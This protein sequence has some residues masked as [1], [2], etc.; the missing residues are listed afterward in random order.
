MNTATEKHHFT[1]PR[2]EGSKLV[3]CANYTP[4]FD[5]N[6]GMIQ[7]S[8]GQSILSVSLSNN[9]SINLQICKVPYK[10]STQMRLLRVGMMKKPRLKEGPV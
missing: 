2:S 9:Q 4:G 10:Q 5:T 7:Q 8:V 6:M 1:A 3:A